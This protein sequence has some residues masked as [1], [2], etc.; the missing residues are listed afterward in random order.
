MERRGAPKLVGRSAVAQEMDTASRL[1]A[2]CEELTG[3]R[4]PLRAPA[5]APA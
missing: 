5:G 1:W 3:F 4:F 2:V